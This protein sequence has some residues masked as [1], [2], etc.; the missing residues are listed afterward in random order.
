MK[1]KIVGAGWQGFTGYFG[2]TEFVDG[3]SAHEVSDIEAKRIAAVVQVETLEG[4]DPSAAQQIIDSRAQPL[5]LATT[6]VVEAPVQDKPVMDHTAEELAAIA[7]KGGI[8]A[9]REAA[10]PFGVKGKSITEIIAALMA[11]KPKVVDQPAAPAE[12]PVAE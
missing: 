1:I 4:T 3:V 11:L 7:D 2:M 8:K 5:I 10:E 9:L 12:A 6:P